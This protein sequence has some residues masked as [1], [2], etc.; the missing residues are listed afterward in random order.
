[1]ATQVQN[2]KAYEYAVAEALS[3]ISGCA[4]DDDLV[5]QHAQRCF[6]AL[7]QS[8]A[9]SFQKTAREAAR[10][11]AGRESLHPGGIGTIRLQPDS[12]GQVG[13]VRDVVVITAGREIGISCK[14]NHEDLKHSRLSKT[15]DFVRSWGIDPSGCSGTY[16]LE[17]EPIFQML[18]SFKESSKGEATWASLGDVPRLVYW[19]ILEAWKR[20]LTRA[21]GEPDSMHQARCGSLA[22]Y[23]FGNRD[24]YKVIGKHGVKSEVNIQGFN[25]NGTLKIPRSKLPGRLVGVDRLNGGSYSLTVRMDRGFTFNFRIHNASSKIEPS[26]KFA[27]KAVSLPPGSIFQETKSL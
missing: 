23:L 3:R 20:E 1:M 4:V 19:P 22:R 21:L 10:V 2:G 17:I 5:H 15:L 13:D 25:F 27:V 12:A 8:Q 14:T 11:I 16:F 26:L 18:K 6:E 7:S 9:L 24:F